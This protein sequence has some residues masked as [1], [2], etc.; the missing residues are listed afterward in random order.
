MQAD[1]ARSCDVSQATISRLADVRDF[2][3]ITFLIFYHDSTCTNVD[4]RDESKAVCGRS[5]LAG[6]WS[7]ADPFCATGRW[8]FGRQV[9]V[10]H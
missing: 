7:I 5:S 9:V 8:R 3:L 2:D 10:S 6:R 1:V 4:R